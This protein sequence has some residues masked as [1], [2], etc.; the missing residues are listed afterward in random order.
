MQVYLR[1]VEQNNMLPIR[2]S[3][4]DDDSLEIYRFIEDQIVDKQRSPSIGEIAR[5]LNLPRSTVYHHLRTLE[6]SQLIYC[7]PNKHCGIQL[8]KAPRRAYL[9]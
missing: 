6:N 1:K 8:L 2:L 5:A 3:D 9:S 7:E 4:L